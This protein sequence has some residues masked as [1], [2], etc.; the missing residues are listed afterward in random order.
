MATETYGCDFSFARPAP[1]AVKAAGYSF[2]MG[3]VSHDAGKALTKAQ[4][5]AYCS[6]GVRVGLV[7]EDAADRALGGAAA[8]AADG[9]FTEQVL[10]DLDYHPTAPVF[11]A[12][13][14]D[15]TA[16]QLPTV[17]QY[18]A[19][20]N[21]ATTHPVGVYGSYR[22]VEALVTP[23]VQ[24]VQYGWQTAAWSSGRLSY[25]AHLYQRNHHTHPLF[26]AAADFDEDVA[27]VALPLMGG[28]IAP[29]PDPT[30]APKPD[31]AP[32]PPK[33]APPKPGPYTVRPGDTLE[34]IA[35]HYGI[36][37]AALVARNPQLARPGTHLAVTRYIIARGDTL[38][39]IAS[40]CNTTLGELVA[41]NSHNLI[42][43]GDRLNA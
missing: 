18:A 32:A 43:P 9:H 4:I 10:R 27:C 31:P 2:V 16:A 26:I 21:R 42:H 3:Y 41:D 19:A 40:R 22:V 6:A 12:V 8:G 17:R 7:F 24:P 11:F 38:A 25:K 1:A 14:F 28:L 5:A 39:A 15:V 35:E 36:T 13:D 37:V 34:S 33:P 20:F 30:P 23:G 29:A